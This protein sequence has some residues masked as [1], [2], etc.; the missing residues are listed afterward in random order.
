MIDFRLYPHQRAFVEWFLRQQANAGLFV[1]PTSAGKTFA[2]LALAAAMDAKK[3]L[4]VAGAMARPTWSMEAKKWYSNLWEPRPVIYGRARKSLTKKQTAQRD[5]SYAASFQVVSFDLADQVDQ[6]GWDLVIVDEVHNLRTPMSQQSRTVRALVKGASAAV[7]LTAT[8]IPTEVKNLWNPIDTFFPGW[9]GKP[10]K[11]GDI[12]WR[13]LEAFCLRNES[14]YGVSYSGVQKDQIPRLKELLLPYVFRVTE[15]DFAHLLP[16]VNADIL[17]LDENLKDEKIVSNWLAEQSE[18]VTHS[19]LVAY[20]HETA[21]K[22]AAA[23]EKA[24]LPVFCITGLQSPET[25]Q[26]IISTCAAAPRAIL[27]ATSECIRESVDLSFVDSVLI[28]EWR[29]SPQAAIQ[30]SGRFGRINRKKVLPTNIRYVAKPGADRQAQIL[31]SRIDAANALLKAD[32]KSELVSQ[33]FSERVYSEE[34]FEKM[35]EQMFSMTAFS[36]QETDDE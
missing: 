29:T 33:I 35:C 8:L 24:G 23:A 5:A 12:S 26:T 17:W 15:A 4:V 34:Q 31:K 27:V 25:R 32:T 10:S 19:A 18:E 7:G 21:A 1:A 28:F 16:P 6:T 30:L 9:Y 36:L 13:F 11:T 22:L 3:V 14:E 20:H 2:S